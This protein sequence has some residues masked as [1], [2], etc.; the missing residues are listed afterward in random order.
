[1]QPATIGIVLFEEVLE[2]L[3][4]LGK[5]TWCTKGGGAETC[6]A[7]GLFCGGG[8]VEDLLA[9][10]LVE[11]EDDGGVA[12]ATGRSLNAF[13]WVYGLRKRPSNFL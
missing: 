4:R 11:T 13:K 3:V 1:M 6:C 7:G 2:L 5:V 8:N 9:S 12:L 10:G